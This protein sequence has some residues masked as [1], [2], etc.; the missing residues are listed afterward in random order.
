MMRDS[1]SFHNSIPVLMTL[2]SMQHHAFT[3]KME[4]LLLFC[5]EV[6]V[7]PDI[8]GRWNIWVC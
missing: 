3:R 5:F 2:I 1:T 4:C 8:I 7:D 6:T